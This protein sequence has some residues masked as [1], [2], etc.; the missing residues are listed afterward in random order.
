MNLRGGSPPPFPP[1]TPTYGRVKREKRRFYS[2]IALFFRRKVSSSFFLPSLWLENAAQRFPLVF[3][4]SEARKKGIV[5]WNKYTPYLSSIIASCQ[6]GGEKR[7]ARSTSL[8]SS[9][10]CLFRS[11]C[12][13]GALYIVHISQYYNA[14]RSRRRSI[15]PPYSC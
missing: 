1:L 6:L 10:L 15:I 11:D 14:F 7:C 5:D 8:P 12:W 3:A 2:L 4:Q 13:I 9:L